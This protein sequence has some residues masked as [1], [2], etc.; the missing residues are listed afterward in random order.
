MAVSK[1]VK[2]SR[3]KSTRPSKKA[4]RVLS[5]AQLTKA[6]GGFEGTSKKTGHL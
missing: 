1:P 2:P 4:K 3:K 5:D 6:A